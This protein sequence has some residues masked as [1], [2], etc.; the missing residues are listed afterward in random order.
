MRLSILNVKYREDDAES[1]HVLHEKAESIPLRP[2]PE[3][4]LLAGKLRHDKPVINTIN[5]ANAL[6]S[7]STT[8]NIGCRLLSLFFL[9]C[10]GAPPVL[11]VEP[12][13]SRRELLG[14]DYVSGSCS[15]REGRRRRRCGGEEDVA[16]KWEV[17]VWG[18]GRGA[19]ENPATTSAT[20]NG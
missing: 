6:C 2:L 13:G 8:F 12:S 17:G 9:G 15:E 10:D 1:P 7:N 11:A 16:A 18:S 5:Y 3:V 4:R 19:A 20:S 14:R